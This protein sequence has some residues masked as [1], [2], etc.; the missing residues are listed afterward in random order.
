MQS[1]SNGDNYKLSETGVINADVSDHGDGITNAD[2][3]V[4]QQVEAKTINLD[5]LPLY[6]E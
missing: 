4:I 3:L 1:L 6:A 5:Q 2:A